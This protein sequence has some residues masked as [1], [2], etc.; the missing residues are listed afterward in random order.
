AERPTTRF[1][2]GLRDIPGDAVRIRALW[3]EV[4]VYDTLEKLYDGIAVYGSRK[5][6]DVAEAY[7]IPPSVQSKLHYCGYIVRDPPAIAAGALRQRHGLPDNGP[8]VLAIVG[9][10]S[11]GYPVLEAARAAV[12]RLQTKFPDLLAI[13]VTGPLMPADKQA[14]LQA[15]ATATCRVVSWA[16][17]SE[18]MAAAD[19]VVSMGG[20]NSVCEALVQARPLVIV[21]RAT[22]KKVEQRIRAETLAAHGLARWVHPNE[23]TGESLAEALEWALHCDRKAHARLVR[24]VIPSF[25]GAAR[26]TAYLSQWLG[27]SRNREDLGAAEPQSKSELR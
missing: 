18:L 5:L 25:D 6:Y 8:L 1:V 22:H 14:R 27:D 13:L 23:L 20:Y 16:D 10:G 12:E 2:F 3:Q 24:D 15:Q 7:A 26:L 21:P 9:S 11:D 4:G 19:A 17:N